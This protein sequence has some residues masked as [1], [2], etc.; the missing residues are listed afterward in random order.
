MT[1]LDPIAILEK[2]NVLYKE[3]KL[4]NIDQNLFK[5]SAP[6]MMPQIRSEQ[7]KSVVK[8]LCEEFNR[9]LEERDR[10]ITSLEDELQ[11]M[12]TGYPNG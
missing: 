12:V 2:A 10:W 6:E 4:K 5:Y 9:Q 7:V 1:K 3:E 8:V 11:E